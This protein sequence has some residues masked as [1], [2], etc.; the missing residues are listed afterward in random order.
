MAA[1]LQPHTEQL[2]DDTKAQQ[3]MLA[4]QYLDEQCP[5]EFGSHMEVTDYV[6]YY[7]HLLAFFANG[8]H[9]GLKK[10]S[11]FVALCGHRETPEVILLKQ[12][13]G[14]HIEVTFN[15]CGALGQFDNAHIEDIIVETPLASVVGKKTKTQLQKLWMSFYHGVQQPAGRACYR[16]KNGDDYE[17]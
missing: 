6:I 16:A 5:L 12:D 17:L 1:Q 15:R 8:T 13:D 11:Q 7:N 2:I 3:S 9:C 10:C 4:K 14:L